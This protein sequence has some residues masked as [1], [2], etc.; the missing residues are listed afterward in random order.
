MYTQKNIWKKPLT[1]VVRVRDF[2][3]NIRIFFV[4]SKYGNSSERKIRYH[5]NILRNCERF[6]KLMTESFTVS[7]RYCMSLLKLFFIL[8]CKTTL[9]MQF[10]KGTQRVLFMITR[11]DWWWWKF[12]SKDNVPIQNFQC[13]STFVLLFCY[14]SFTVQ[15]SD[16]GLEIEESWKT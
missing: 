6:H 14:E 16:V 12:C 11:V 7:T 8:Y 5:L 1:L 15:S 3:E 10:D 9:E 4:F 13:S 2:I